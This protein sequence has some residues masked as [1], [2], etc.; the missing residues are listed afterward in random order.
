MRLGGAVTARIRLWA[1]KPG[2]WRWSLTSGGL[3]IDAG[4]AADRAA[5]RRAAITAAA[6]RGL[7]AELDPGD[8]RGNTEPR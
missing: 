8:Y 7:S 5:A 2:D 1:P 4:T 6:R 3:E